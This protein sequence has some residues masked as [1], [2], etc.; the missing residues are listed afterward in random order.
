MKLLMLF[1]LILIERLV[2]DM[3]GFSFM[4]IKDVRM[5]VFYEC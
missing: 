4:N 3:F 1:M 5:L 2:I